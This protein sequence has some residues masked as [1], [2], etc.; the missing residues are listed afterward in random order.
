MMKKSARDFF[1]RSY[2][3]ATAQKI[4][5]EQG[6]HAPHLW[7]EMAA[8]GWLGLP[9]PEPYGGSGADLLDVVVLLEEMGRACLCGPYFSTVVLCALTIAEAGSETQKASLLPRIAGGDL[10]M[11]LAAREPGARHEAEKTDTRALPA[12]G[13]FRLAGSKQ[14]VSDAHLSQYLLCPA[15]TGG[16]LDTE[17][18]VTLFLVETDS[19]GVSCHPSATLIC[20]TQSTVILDNVLVGRSGA[21]GAPGHGRGPLQHTMD[22]GSVA[23]CAEMVGAAD[24]VLDMSV[25]YARERVQFGHPIGSYQ[26]IQ[27]YC[28]DMAVDLDA[29]RW[30]TG[31]AA[32]RLGRDL[33]SGMEVSMAKALVNEACQRIAIQG[34]QIHGG[35]GFCDDHPLH[36]YFRRIRGGS[37][38]L[39]DTSFHN[40]RVA[41]EL[42]AGR[43]LFADMQLP[44]DNDENVER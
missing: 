3:L 6:G 27:H 37:L 34:H 40:G 8:L 5:R 1:S 24:A 33:N 4:L 7:R 43:P 19:P 12:E 22:R 25:A 20:E 36:L 38:A 44:A 23:R 26:A 21:L 9:L 29:S 13:G 35:I 42:V 32:W 16:A 10:I 18:S 14:L 28:A 11:A 39:G 17:D 30:M 41:A 2:P 15:R 31:Y